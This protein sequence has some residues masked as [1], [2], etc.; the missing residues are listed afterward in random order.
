MAA[1]Q[2][3]VKIYRKLQDHWL[4]QDK[5]FSRGQA[6][7]DLILLANHKDGTAVMDG[8]KVE[9]PTGC[10]VT[11]LR[12]LGDRW[13]W[14]RTKVGRFLNLLE[15]ENMLTQNSD[16]KKTVIR[17]ENYG[18]LQGKQTQSVTQ[19]RHGNDTGVT[20]KNTNKNNKEYIKNGEEGA[21][22]QFAPPGQEGQGQKVY[23]DDY[24]RERDGG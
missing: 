2:G 3:Y 7:I 4:W 1:K 14:S 5:P 17:L 6:W 18:I 9:V 8:S 22:A 20:Q 24:Y 15:N 16:T 10:L 23:L 19:K 11:S 12:K 13:G 21:R